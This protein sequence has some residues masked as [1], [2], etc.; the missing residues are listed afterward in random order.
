MIF[1]G[2]LYPLPAIEESRGA[3]IASI[4]LIA[5]RRDLRAA[6]G[7]NNIPTSRGRGSNRYRT[8]LFSRHLYKSDTNLLGIFPHNMAWPSMEIGLDI[9]T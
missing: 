3:Y 7:P 9:E 1:R 6:T 4:A 8:Q 2:L 5:C